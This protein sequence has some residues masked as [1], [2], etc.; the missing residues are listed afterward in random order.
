MPLRTTGTP[1][2]NAKCASMDPIDDPHFVQPL[3]R[4]V[5]AGAAILVSTVVVRYSLP[6]VMA[7]T[8]MAGRKGRMRME[9]QECVV[10]MSEL[11]LATREFSRETMKSMAVLEKAWRIQGSSHRS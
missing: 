9:S 4:S 1:P 2:S 3:K 5:S 6:T 11:M 8:V 10:E 7:T